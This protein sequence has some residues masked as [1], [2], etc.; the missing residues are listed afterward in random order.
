[1]KGQQGQKYNDR[2]QHGA[3]SGQLADQT[4]HLIHSTVAATGINQGFST[5]RGCS[6]LRTTPGSKSLPGLLRITAGEK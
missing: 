1:M 2:K 5:S 3:D 4:R 6:G